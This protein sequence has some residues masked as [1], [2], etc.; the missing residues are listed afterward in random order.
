MTP[1]GQERPQLRPLAIGEILD[2][3][4]KI[5]FTHWRTLL[6]AALVVVVPVQ[7]AITILT[8]DYTTESFDFSSSQTPEET[9]EELNEYIGG[10][11][12]S[13]ILQAS[14]VL[15]ASAAC[16]RAI[17][18]AYLG[19]QTDWRASLAYA[20]RRAPQLLLITLLYV[21]GWGFATLFFIAPGVWLYVAWAFAL[22]VLLVEGLRGPKAL[23]RSFAL[24]R[25]R[26]WRTFGVLVLGF[27]LALVVSTV[28]QGVFLLGLFA[29]S[30]ND[31]F[32]LI[33][34][35]VAGTVGLAITTPFQAALLAVV[36]FDLR[37]R[38]EGFDLELLA[39]RIGASV[40]AGRGGPAPTTPAP[41][42]VPP[43][44]PAD[45][46]ATAGADGDAPVM[47]W[48]APQPAARPAR[49]RAPARQES[50]APPPPPGWPPP[51][52]PANGAADGGD[53]AAR[54]EPRDEP[55]DEPPR[56]PGVPHG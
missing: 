4:I 41:G 13:G 53:R 42:A 31:L 47:H 32:V 35:A 46:E 50:A 54:R 1:P 9:L 43:P 7:I 6:A 8:A 16:F 17:A 44:A 36:Y 2:V 51:P 20:I 24:V 5:F 26:W 52:P 19:E 29:G 56:L 10:L 28:I 33:L 3:A 55:P 18:Q 12:I 39:E 23:G 14:A 30:E 49:E 27:V 38:K 48:P 25:G 45:A 11:A 22:P 40:P 37:V 34:S 21:L 15:L